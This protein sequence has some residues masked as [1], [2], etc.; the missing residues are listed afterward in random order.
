MTTWARR[1][2]HLLGVT[3]VLAAVLLA[4][5][6]RPL[7]SPLDGLGGSRPAATAPVVT[8]PAPGAG[9]AAP[10]PDSGV[11]APTPPPTTRPSAPPAPCPATAVGSPAGGLPVGCPPPATT[12]TATTAPVAPNR[13]APSPSAPARPSCPTDPVG[14]LLGQA[15][16][17][18]GVPGTAGSLADLLAIATGCSTTDPLGATIDL[19][20]AIADVLPSFGIDPIDLPDLPGVVLPVPDPILDLL[21]PIA[22]PLRDGCASLSV[23]A[24]VLALL[25]PALNLPVFQSDLAQLLGPVYAVCAL[26]DERPS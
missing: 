20:S 22:G 6:G 7:P 14:A 2:R 15:L 9:V 13:P 1:N 10:T 23:V 17:T 24:L 12:T 16:T 11:T 21:A 26:F 25:P 8:A 5:P 4:F 18:L 19:A 3:G